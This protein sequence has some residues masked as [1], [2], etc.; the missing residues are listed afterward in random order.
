MPAI[1]SPRSGPIIRRKTEEVLQKAAQGQLDDCVIC[2]EPIERANLAFLDS[3]CPHVFC[4]PCI[5]RNIAE[6]PEKNEYGEKMD[7]HCPYRCAKPSRTV[8]YNL[9]LSNSKGV[10]F[11]LFPFIFILLY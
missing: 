3:C 11:F 2:Q 6:T 5:A 4:L 10:I 8:V 1:R 9:A 7:H